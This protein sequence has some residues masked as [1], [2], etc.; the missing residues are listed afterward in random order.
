MFFNSFW[1]KLS[2]ESWR[3]SVLYTPPYTKSWL[4]NKISMFKVVTS[5]Q[6]YCTLPKKINSLPNK[7][8]Y[9]INEIKKKKRNNEFVVIF[10]QFKEMNTFIF[11]PLEFRASHRI[12]H[13]AVDNNLLS[14]CLFIQRKA[15]IEFSNCMLMTTLIYVGLMR[16]QA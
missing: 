8:S 12:L 14:M 13:P 6:D 3:F 11:F 1:F 15:S 9:D 7:I 5:N 16:H 4:E 10:V 2:T